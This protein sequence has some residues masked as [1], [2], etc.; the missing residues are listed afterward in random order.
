MRIEIESN[1]EEV[2]QLFEEAKARWL[3][4]ASQILDRW[5]DEV[6]S[7]AQL[8]APVDTGFLRANIQSLGVKIAGDVITGSVQ[9]AAEY[10]TFVED[11]TSRMAAQP[12]LK[13]SY[14][15]N[16]EALI[17]ELTQLFENYF[18]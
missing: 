1:I 7:D 3:A 14:E 4:D 13:P 17:E 15:Q 2:R 12:F 16:I 5:L 9:S 10:S 18:E 11:G 6:E 8:L